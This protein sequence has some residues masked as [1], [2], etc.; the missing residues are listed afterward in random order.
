MFFFLEFSKFQKIVF[1]RDNFQK[2]ICSGVFGP[3]VDY[4]PA[5]SLKGNSSISNLQC[6]SKIPLQLFQ[7]ILMEISMMKFRGLL[8]CRL[9]SPVFLLKI[10][11]PE[12][13]QKFLKNFGDKVVS[14]KSP[15]WIPILVATYNISKDKLVQGRFPSG[16]CEFY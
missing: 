16:Y 14:P 8:V 7:N 11:P 15:R 3:V 1:F 4:S 2:S 10:N 5:I 13:P 12:T 6:F 9:Y